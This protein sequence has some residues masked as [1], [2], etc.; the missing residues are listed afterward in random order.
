MFE[1]HRFHAE[2]LSKK[3]HQLLAYRQ[4]CAWSNRKGE[5]THDANGRIVGYMQCNCD[6]QGVADKR[7]T[8]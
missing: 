3:V 2:I 7:S 4:H 1:F 5:Y 8:N 6:V